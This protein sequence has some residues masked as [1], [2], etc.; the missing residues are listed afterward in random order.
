[1][2]FD[3][4]IRDLIVYANQAAATMINLDEARIDGV[5]LAYNGQFGDTAVRLAA[6]RQNPRDAKSGQTLLRRAKNFSSLGVTQQF[7]MLQV[8]GEW[9][10]SGART[11]GDIATFERTTLAAYDVANLTASYKLNPHFDLSA[12]VD[13]LFNRDYMLVHG[14]NTLGR[15]L[16]VGVSYR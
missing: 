13:N 3:N 9:Q 11:D 10:H 12:R 7:G 2:Y 4:R 6:T 5:E 15:T 16:F 14:Y 8:G 1:V